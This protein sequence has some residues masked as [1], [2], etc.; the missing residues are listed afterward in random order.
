MR[1]KE[2]KR[3]GSSSSS[4]SLSLS[5]LLLLLLF[6][7]QCPVS[8]FGA[9][10]DCSSLGPFSP[11]P[12]RS[13]SLQSCYLPLVHQKK[14]VPVSRLVPAE[15]TTTKSLSRNS[16][17]TKTKIKE[18]CFGARQKN[19]V[20]PLLHTDQQQL[21]PLLLLL[22]LLFSLLPLLMLLLLLLSPVPRPCL[23]AVQLLL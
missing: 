9:C 7:W 4:P 5:L 23:E 11:P 3:E 20:T 14:R 16:F 1:E 17:G 19:V 6:A 8:E 18:I 2:R 10:V 12:S 13:P 21:L 22:L 15:A